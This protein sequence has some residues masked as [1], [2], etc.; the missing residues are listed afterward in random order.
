MTNDIH[1]F[2]MKVIAQMKTSF[3]M[4]DDISQNLAAPRVLKSAEGNKILLRKKEDRVWFQMRTQDFENI[5][6]TRLNVE[7]NNILSSFCFLNCDR[8]ILLWVIF[9]KTVDSAVPFGSEPSATK[10]QISVIMCQNW[11][12][13]G[14]MTW[15]SVTYWPGSGG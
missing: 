6:Q 9:N 7:S 3:K 5:T 1:M 12:K 8:C 4:A 2:T 10:I 11:D 14:A 15:R 13:N